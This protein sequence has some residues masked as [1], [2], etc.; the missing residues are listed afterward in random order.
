M[1]FRVGKNNYLRLS[2]IAFFTA[3]FLFFFFYPL[4]IVLLK[5]ISLNQNSF[6]DFISILVENKTLIWNSFYQA[7]IS[8]IFSLLVGI[9]A[10]YLI[11]RK[12][13][14][15]KK[16][17]K[18]ISLVPFV[19]PSVL[20][21]LAFVILLGNNGW[22]NSIL[23]N[24]FGFHIQFL[25][26]FL[27][28]ILAHVFFNFP[29][30]MRFVSSSWENLDVKMKESA[31]TLGANNF[32]VFLRITLPQLLPS[33]IASASLVFIFCFTS[34]AIITTLGGLQFSTLEVEIYRQILRNLDF[35]TGAFFALFQF[36]VLSIIA[37]LYFYFSKKHSVSQKSNREPLSKFNFSSLR[38]IAEFSFLIFIIVIALLPIFAIAVFAFFDPSTGDFTLRAFEKIFSVSNVT[39]FET[40]AITAVLLSLFLAFFAALVSSFLGLIA[41]LK[42]T[43]VPFVNFFASCS[44]AVSVITLA[45]GYYL[46]FGSGQLLIIAIGHSILAFPFAFRIINNAL[47]Q[48]DSESIDSAKTLGADDVSVFI[49]IQFPR[50]KKALIASMAFAFAISLGELGL[51]LVLYDGIFATMPVYIYRLIS[52]YDLFA[53]GAMGFLLFAF[54]FIAFYAIEFFSNDAEVF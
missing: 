8:T 12:D 3:F 50:I 36:I 52:T 10:A 26:G 54:S 31:K 38:G 6:S 22:V 29:I 35:A 14:P 13:F 16:I 41:S 46:G 1:D 32:D 33:I 7:S 18:A 51:V 21:V 2:L 24:L 43:N 44:I 5:S 19:F 49:K 53:A 37:S 25:Y 47:L 34:F 48:V 40:N 28:I 27:G 39:L 9:P 23:K 30:V 15:G 42:Q 11:A 20:V 4:A 45:F 17:V